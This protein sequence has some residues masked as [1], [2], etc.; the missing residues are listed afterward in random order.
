MS[1]LAKLGTN[2]RVGLALWLVAVLSIGAVLP[3][4]LSLQQAAVVAAAAKAGIGV[5][6][7][8]ALSLVQS[9]LFIGLLIAV[10]T[11]AAGR[12]GLRAPFVEAWV[13][14]APLPPWRALIPAVAIGLLAGAAVAVLDLALFLELS[15]ELK[16][17]GAT[18]PSAWQGFLASFYGGIGEEVQLR[19]CL[20]S[21]LALG[22]AWIGA[23]L[24]GAPA[25]RL[26]PTAFWTA[27][28]VAAVVF[29]LAHLPATATLVPLTDAIVV[30]AVVLNAV[31]AI[32]CG[33]LFWRRGLEAAMAAHFAADLVLHV[34]VPL[35]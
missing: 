7:L 20:L 6:T 24:A 10:G 31:V 14:G 23:R 32:P 4:A 13:T 1:V 18:A 8:I 19:W 35:L 21:L 33:W 12:L 25:V 30:R 3:Y 27:N 29:G 15:P 9:A 16:A 11:W 2:A 34:L 28:V 22:F 17:L 26:T 5:G